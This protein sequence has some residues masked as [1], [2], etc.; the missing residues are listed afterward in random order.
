GMVS[1]VVRRLQR[2]ILRSIHPLSLAADVLT[3]RLLSFVDLAAA[4]LVVALMSAIDRPRMTLVVVAGA[5]LVFALY[6]GALWDHHGPA[7]LPVSI[8]RGVV[9]PNSLSWRARGSNDWREIENSNIGYTVRQLPL[10]GVGLG[11]EYLFQREP[12]ALTNFA[13]RRMMPSNWGLRLYRRLEDPLLRAAGSCP[14]LVTV[15]QIVFSSVDLGL[16]YHRTMIVFGVALGFVAPLAVCV[17]S[18]E[19]EPSRVSSKMAASEPQRGD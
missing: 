14:V 3:T 9:D 8:V 7:A 18:A 12:P 17:R 15:A 4:L 10:T 6:A 11:Q 13:Y 19:P 16:T 5:T 1:L 2:C